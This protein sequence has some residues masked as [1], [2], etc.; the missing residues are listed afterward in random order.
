M[1]GPS[2]SPLLSVEIVFGTPE[3]QEL[4]QLK[5]PPG[6]S[7]REAVVE[8][9][10]AGRF[11]GIDIACLQAGIWGKPVAQSRLLADGDRVEIYRPLLIDPREARRALAAQGRSMGSEAESTDERRD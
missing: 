5:I 6:S 7:V 3:R 4:L 10:I 11:P 9:G 1:A 8:S 2:G